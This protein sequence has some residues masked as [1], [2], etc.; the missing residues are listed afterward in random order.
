[1]QEELGAEDKEQIRRERGRERGR[2]K[3]GEGWGTEKELHT[4]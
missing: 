2:R 4:I 1:M 3:D